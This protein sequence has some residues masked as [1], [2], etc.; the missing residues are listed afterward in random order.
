MRWV[1]RRPLLAIALTLLPAAAPVAS[2]AVA[3]GVVA[4]L[5]S[6]AS[7]SGG[8]SGARR[9]G[10]SNQQKCGAKPRDIRSRSGPGRQLGELFA[11][12]SPSAEREEAERL[13]EQAEKLRT[14]IDGFQQE[15]R[16]LEEE[17][18][19]KAESE[20]AE[21][22]RVRDRFSAVVPILKPDGTTVEERVEFPPFRKN[23]NEEGKE[24]ASFITVCES[25]LPL[26]II[27]GESEEYAGAVS[28]DEVAEGSNGAAAG[29]QVRDILR[30]FSACKMYMEQPAWNLIG[31]GIGRPKLFRLM[32][33][34][35]GKPFEEVME[36]IASNRMDPE[37][38]PVLLV[39][40]RKS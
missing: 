10:S 21:R 26:G 28:V 18:N 13:K 37:S 17:E 3:T 27:L 25:S 30:A 38:R 31:G 4:F 16:R 14:E 1:S 29:V 19:R 39:L 24:E 32:Y 5:C 36:A 12:S 7:S 34:V 40:E 2:A 6:R 15:K 35:D 9:F 33:L 22:Q 11:S 20:R 8:R 23:E